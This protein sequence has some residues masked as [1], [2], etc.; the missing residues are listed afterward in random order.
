MEGNIISSNTVTAPGDGGGGLHLFFSD[1]TLRANLIADNVTPGSG[2]GLWLDYSNCTLEGNLF[3]G[4]AADLSG[5]G[6]YV[7]NSAPFMMTNN[8]IA[9]NAA[10]ITGGGL[11]VSAS[12]GWLRHSTIANNGDAGV[13]AT[14]STALHFTN[15]IVVSQTVGLNVLAGSAVTLEATLWHGNGADTSGGGSIVTGTVNFWGDPAFADPMAGDYHLR[16]GS[17]A[18]D[19]GIDAGVTSDLDYEPRPYHAPDL[20]A[21]EYWPPGALKRLYLPLV[22]RN[23]T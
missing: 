13:Y 23:Y 17:T 14:G 6:L 10:A 11:C 9:G 20:G 16:E 7:T 8:V 4:N 21:D 22:L 2:A 12:K 19:R 15:T 1:A 5:G 3:I 18:L